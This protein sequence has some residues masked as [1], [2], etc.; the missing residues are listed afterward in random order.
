[1]RKCIRMRGLALAL[2]FLLAAGCAGPALSARAAETDDGF[3]TEGTYSFTADGGGNVQEQDTFVFR[4]DCFM[5]SSF[6]GCAHLAE[7]SAQAAM[8]SASRYGEGPDRYEKDPSGNARN[9]T[10]LL[11]AAGFEDVETNRY[12]TLEKQENSMGTAVGRRTVRAFG[13]VYTLL[14]VIPRSAGYKQEWAGNF[15]VGDGDLH[16]GFKAARDEILRFMKQY[17]EQHNV[18][19]ELKVWMAGHSRGG[20]VCSL[21]GGFLAD[22]GAAYFGGRVSLQPE[23]VY[24][25]T[26]AAPRCV[27]ETVSRREELSVAGARAD[28]AYADDTPG[29][30]YT[31]DTD[32][33]VDVQDGIFGGVRN[34]IFSDD[35]IPQ[36]PPADWGL[37]HYGTDLPAEQ[38]GIGAEVMAAELEQISPRSRKAFADGGDYRGFARYT[39]DLPS[40]S[41]IPDETADGAQTLGVFMTARVPGLMAGCET[42]GEYVSE[43]Y[44]ETMRH[45][46]AL[47]GLLMS[48]P[49]DALQP[50][51]QT[52]VRPAVLLL[53][54]Y[55]A[56][57]MQAERGARDEA[58]GITMALEDLLA[59]VSGKNISHE[60]FTMDDF[61]EIL[62]VWLN[63]HENDPAG[64][65]A[66]TAMENA[67][68]EKAASA[69]RT[70]LGIF[71]KDNS[72][73]RPV[74]AAEAVRAYLKACAVG[75]DPECSAAA[76]FPTAKD[77]RSLL[78][79]VLPLVLSFTDY[80]FGSVLKDEGSHPFGEAVEILLPLLL[81]ETDADGNR[82]VYDSV[83]AAADEAAAQVLEQLVGPLAEDAGTHVGSAY[84]AIIRGHLDA[85]KAR[86]GQLRKTLSYFL[87]Y[88]KGEAYDTARM[89]AGVCTLAANAKIIPTA[90][91]NEC[92]IAWM[93]AARKAG[94]EPEHGITQ[95]PGR[96]PDYERDGVRAHWVLKDGG[97]KRYFTDRFL[98]EEL[99][100]AD[101]VIPRETQPELP[102]SVPGLPESGTETESGPQTET[103]SAEAGT[104]GGI[105][106]ETAPDEAGTGQGGETV[107]WVAVGLLAAGGA[108]AGVLIAR[109]KTEGGGQS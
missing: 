86:A 97:E 104:R 54:S 33:H 40:L 61:L 69:V 107:L 16:E 78:Y 26:Y 98:S 58:E 99:T 23:D 80:E 106:P 68:P 91:Y 55:A 73:F 29:D 30:P 47:I 94:I 43:G 50:D 95:D 11:T 83:A 77:A 60:T 6:S 32:G 8:A 51:V 12:Y 37:T 41:L 27:R 90:H 96:Q 18:T 59:W 100:E 57:R 75:P 4:E 89:A 70:L 105:A 42:A 88:T 7:L 9:V 81:Q 76:A 44:Q 1:M 13:H 14:A 79:T 85:L 36:L 21:L 20:A 25:Y 17:I 109:K 3:I 46:G 92:Y 53:L 103:Q 31:P 35:V 5:R 22:G 66:L 52:L 101:L 71:H 28:A 63:D 38:E 24:C 93:R 2:A 108:L 67:V 72:L 62:A 82:T 45:A 102:A 49:K 34:Y 10:E 56:E 65:A 48:Y 87:L 19:G 74:S 39:F 64:A 84:Q 15:T